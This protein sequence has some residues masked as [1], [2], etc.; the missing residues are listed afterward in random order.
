MEIHERAGGAVLFNGDILDLSPGSAPPILID[1]N[2]GAITF[3]GKV[4]LSSGSSDAILFSNP[5]AESAVSFTGGG[6]DIDTTS[7]TGLNASGTGNGATLRI[8]GSN[9]SV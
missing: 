8:S 4:T 5:G 2:D 1:R 3:A 7:G 6:L 9:N